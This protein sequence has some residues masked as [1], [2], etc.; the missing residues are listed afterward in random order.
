MP[1]QLLHRAYVVAG[2]EQVGAKLW[3][4]VWGETGFTSPAR[5][6]AARTARWTRLD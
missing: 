6:A 3:R 2:F 5:P 4:G 1:E